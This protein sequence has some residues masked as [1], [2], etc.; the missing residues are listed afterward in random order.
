VTAVKAPLHSKVNAGMA[1]VQVSDGVV[2]VEPTTTTAASSPAVLRTALALQGLDVSP[3]SNAV[4]IHDTVR[5]EVHAIGGDGSC[6][7]VGSLDVR[8]SSST[9]ASG[10]NTGAGGLLPTQRLQE[11]VGGS[12]GGGGSGSISPSRR[13]TAS[14][15]TKRPLSSSS[16]PGGGGISNEERGGGGTNNGCMAL[17]EESVFRLAGDRVEVCNFAGAS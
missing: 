5:A 3:G 9:A 6:V 12:T 16:R 10:G 17:I 8:G 7:L 13:P 14:A 2:V 11:G 4:L 1:V 15:G